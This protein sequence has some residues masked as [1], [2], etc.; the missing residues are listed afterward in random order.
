MKLRFAG[1][2]ALALALAACATGGA[3]FLDV[4]KGFAVAEAAV[5]AAA[6]AAD[7][8]V[9]SGVTTKAQNLAIAKDAMAA[10]IWLG[11]AQNAQKSGDAA[12]LAS[13]V[14]QLNALAALLRAD[15]P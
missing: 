1:A 6:L 2:L 11:D 15:H 5:D 8:A 9:K 10:A 7:V 13:A 3:T 14:A 4:E 12:K